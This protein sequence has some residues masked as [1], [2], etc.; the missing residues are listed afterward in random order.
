MKRACKQRRD[1]RDDLNMPGTVRWGLVGST[2]IIACVIA[3]LALGNASPSSSDA[4]TPLSQPS[5]GEKMTQSAQAF[6]DTLN[7][8]QKESVVLPYD[9]PKR[10]DWHFIPKADRKGLQVH[11]MNDAQR[12][13]AYHLL[14]ESLSAAG[15][16]KARQIMKLEGLLHQLEQA[17]GGG[18]NIRDPLRYYFTLFGDVSQQGR[19]GLSIEGHHLSLNFVVEAN[20]VISITPHSFD[21][22]PAEVKEAVGDY[23]KGMRVISD[24]ETRAFDLINALTPAQQTKAII[25]EQAIR[26]VRAAGE[27]QP[28]QTAPAT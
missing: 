5:A 8:D 7:A 2:L 13:A 22:N 6:L 24:A 12:D 10:V 9:T 15:Y 14:R 20:Q 27:A 1:V 11:D 23:P 4:S 3:F 28:P 19:W 25:A 16:Q 26:E 17:R 18:G 21:T